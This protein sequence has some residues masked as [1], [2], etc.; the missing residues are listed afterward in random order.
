MPWH[1]SCLI[2][3]SQQSV[4]PVLHTL[5]HL[6]DGCVQDWFANV[7]IIEHVLKTIVQQLP[8]IKKIVIRSDNAASYHN[9]S[10]LV[11]LKDVGD[12][13]NVG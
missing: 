1:V 4:G 5:F 7:S 13:T 6:F 2:S 11:A 3:Q 10:L 9:A 8:H 12:R